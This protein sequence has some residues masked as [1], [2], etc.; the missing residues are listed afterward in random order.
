[1]NEALVR[2][3]ASGYVGWHP[4]VAVLLLAFLLLLSCIITFL[5]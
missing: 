3:S 4:R 2:S 5:P 1:M